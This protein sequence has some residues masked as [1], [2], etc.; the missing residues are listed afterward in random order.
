M[1]LITVPALFGFPP[2]QLQSKI[3]SRDDVMFVD[4]GTSSTGEN[5]EIAWQQ[6][7]LRLLPPCLCLCSMGLVGLNGRLRALRRSAKSSASR[8]FS[9]P[10]KPCGP[11]DP[12]GQQLQGHRLCQQRP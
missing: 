4:G 9:G 3:V 10:T 5:F 11:G 6:A 8:E 7:Q 12:A 1:R 2:P